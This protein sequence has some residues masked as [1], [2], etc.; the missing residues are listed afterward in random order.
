MGRY[1]ESAVISRFSELNIQNRFYLQ[2]EIIALQEDL[3]ELEKANNR[4]PDANKAAFSRNRYQL[5]SSG[6][7]DSSDEQWL[8]VFS[9]KEKLKEYSACAPCKDL[10]KA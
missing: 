4:S 2:A 8:L 6:E 1:A 5:S 9:I 10:A 3:R 7:Q